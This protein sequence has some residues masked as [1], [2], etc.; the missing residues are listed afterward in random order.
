MQQEI[1]I[2]I[3]TKAWS[4]YQVHDN[5]QSTEVYNS[6][7]ARMKPIQVQNW[8][9]GH[10]SMLLQYSTQCNLLKP[11]LDQQKTVMHTCSTV[12]GSSTN[13]MFW[14]NL[15]YWNMASVTSMIVA[16]GCCWIQKGEPC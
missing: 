16:V 11:I 14:K 6:E 9:V 2:L 13:Q 8:L 5:W 1:N 15:S 7:C 12:G 3:S 4:V 10:A